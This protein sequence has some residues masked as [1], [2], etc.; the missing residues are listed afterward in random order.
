MN[1][2]QAKQIPIVEILSKLG[3]LPVRKD[4][5]G[6]EWVYNSPFRN[7][8]VPSFFVN[9]QKN[10]WNDFGD[11]GGNVLDFVIKHEN[12]TVKGALEFLDRLSGRPNTTFYRYIEKAP[13][14]DKQR[15]PKEKSLELENVMPLKSPVLE[16]YLKSRSINISIARQY[17]KVVQFKHKEKGTKYFGLGLKNLSGDY[18]VRNPKLKTVVGQKDIS[19]I[20]GKKP[21][22]QLVVFESFTDFLSYL[23]DK[24]KTRLEDDVMI[25]NSAN[26]TS[27]AKEFIEKK[28]YKKLYTFLDNDRAGQE[29]L[30]SL[31]ELSCEIVACNHLYQGFKDYNEYLQNQSKTINR[32]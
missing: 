14:T 13:H 3:Y 20:E 1:S 10:V 16:K 32:N 9:V 19:F 5:G 21:S 28:S 6:V 27:K 29:A 8:S 22:G 2:K 4:K 30:K 24:R 7:E 25:L 12:T 26:M 17:L 15:L 18:E 31:L 11:M 23:T